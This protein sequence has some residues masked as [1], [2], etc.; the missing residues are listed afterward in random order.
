MS[1]H[2]SLHYMSTGTPQDERLREYVCIL[3]PDDECQQ[4]Y[5]PV[6]EL[7]VNTTHPCT[8]TQLKDGQRCTQLNS[9]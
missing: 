4:Y 5:V 6:V 7:S 9:L 2:N 8:Q 3:I 1:G